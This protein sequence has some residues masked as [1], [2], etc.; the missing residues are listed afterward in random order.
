MFTK[1][2][3]FFVFGSILVALAFTDGASQ[4][5]V[6]VSDAVLGQF[7]HMAS[8]RYYPTPESELDMDM[9]EESSVRDGF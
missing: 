3:Q 9:E 7:K 8:L 6:G 5:I 4:F 1:C 2:Q